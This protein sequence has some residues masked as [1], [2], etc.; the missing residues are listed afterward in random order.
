M[1]GYN[2]P[3]GWPNPQAGVKPT[4][5]DRFIAAAEQN[6]MTNRFDHY[7]YWMGMRPGGDGSHWG[8]LLLND[9]NVQAP[10][11]RW[12]CVEQMVKLNNPVSSA[13]GEHAIW[14][15]GVK[16]S[17]L[18]QGFPNGTWSGGIFTQNPAG[19]PF[20]GFQWRN[21]S[22]LNLNWLW[23]QVYATS[24]SGSLKY[25]HV[26]AAK[27]YIGCLASGSTVPSV[28]PTVS[29]TAPASG[30]T[31]S[32]TTLLSANA[33]DDV[34]VT[35]V[36]FKLNGANI[37]AE[38]TTAPY[39]IAWN[40]AAVANGSHVITAVARDGAGNTTTS[41]AV[42]VTVNNAVA[43]GL[44][45]ND[46]PSFRTITDQQWDLLNGNGW[47]FLRRTASRNPDVVADPTAPFSAV[48]ALRM[49]FTTDMQRDSEPSVHWIGLA[50]P[51][52]VYSGWWMKV[53][54][55]W[56]CSP[57]GCGKITFL[58]PDHA[59]GAGVTYSNLADAGNGQHYVN[60]ATT[61][62][63][64][65]YR[66]WEPNVTRTIVSKAQWFRVE[67]YVKWESSPG[68]GDGIIRWW[69]NGVLNGDYHNVPFP[70]IAGFLEF[71]HAP[72]LQNVPSAEQY[73][74]IDHTRVRT[75]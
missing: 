70:T 48:N 60:I 52:E 12:V 66:F 19:S 73:M 71:Q 21:T 23:L 33:S 29:I 7:A 11:D 53:S 56:A 46:P 35:G 14:L 50:R 16:V 20:P 17:H 74:Y 10:A 67:W 13:N 2:P 44:W 63:A 62:P 25:A 61:W 64:T 54:P 5:S 27:S 34:A 18:G 1:G 6:T 15:D 39:S 36:Q 26:V 68:A 41:A 24:G 51:R 69:V 40:S 43:S 75:P 4:G 32:G 9:P 45:P 65:G 22:N 3:L 38:D 37:G 55:N 72:T 31:V 49:I 47:N 59:N 58:F 30:A 28:P 42:T 8:N 57:A